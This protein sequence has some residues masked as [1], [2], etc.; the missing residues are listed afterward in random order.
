ML[1]ILGGVLLSAW[2][3]PLMST[4]ERI[5]GVLVFCRRFTS[6][7]KGAILGIMDKMLSLMST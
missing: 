2:F 6:I 5:L 4:G 3:N 7:P 1:S